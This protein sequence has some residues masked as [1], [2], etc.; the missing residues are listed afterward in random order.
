MTRQTSSMQVQPGE[1][2]PGAAYAGPVPDAAQPDL[3]TL[4][5]PPPAAATPEE[6]AGYLEQLATLACGTGVYVKPPPL[7]TEAR[8][9]AL[10]QDTEEALV[11][12]L[13]DVRQNG[14]QKLS[15][16]IQELEQGQHDREPTAT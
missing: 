2:Q 13:K 5:A 8:A 6:W 1:S 14:G 4:A 10:G 7:S 15:E 9:W 3:A 11:R 12:E 16:L